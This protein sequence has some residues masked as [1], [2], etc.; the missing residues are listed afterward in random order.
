MLAHRNVRAV[1][2][3][4]RH[5]Q[6]QEVATKLVADAD[7]LVEN[8]R[9]GVME[10]F[11]LGY[12]QARTINPRL[13]YASASGYGSDSPFRDLPGQ[14]LLIQARSGLAASTGRAGEA[15]GPAGGALLGPHP[16]G[17]RAGGG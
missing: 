7:V 5:P 17:A 9:P 2:L 10:R 3:N 12:E 1:T 16:G 15:P 4:L 13:I 8:Y 14:D 6:A 11:G